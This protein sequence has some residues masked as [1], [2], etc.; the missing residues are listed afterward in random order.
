M[1]NEILVD[2]F[3]SVPESCR[4]WASIVESHVNDD[5]NVQYYSIIDTEC[6]KNECYCITNDQFYDAY[7]KLNSE[8][9]SGE[10]SEWK[11]RIITDVITENYDAETVDMLFQYSIFND[12]MYG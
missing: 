11:K 4:Y 5:M 7:M 10:I 1:I 12:L 6:G 2:M 9:V 8:A 3:D